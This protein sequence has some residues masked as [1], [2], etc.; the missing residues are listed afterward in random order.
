MKHLVALSVVLAV[1]AAAPALSRAQSGGMKGMDMKGM[2][3]KSMD[4]KGMESGT[5]VPGT[6]HKGAGTVKTVDSAKGAVTIAH[7]P[8]KSLNWPAMTMDFEVRDNAKLA[9]LK[10]GQKIEFE[11]IE[12]QGKYAITGVK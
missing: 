5:K 11:F 7:G 10:P 6:V 1:F 12:E 2:D 4:M 3:M 8:V 9:A